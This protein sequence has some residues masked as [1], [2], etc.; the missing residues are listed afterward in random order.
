[1]RGNLLANTYVL[2]DAKRKIPSLAEKFDVV[3]AI[4]LM[5]WETPRGSREDA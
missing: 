4:V 2:D 5:G 1:M 3:V